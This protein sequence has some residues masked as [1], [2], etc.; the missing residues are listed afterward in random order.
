M[1]TSRS[2]SASGAYIA[3][4]LLLVHD[5]ALPAVA[6]F[7][8]GAAL[9]WYLLGIRSS[10]TSRVLIRI[11]TN[12][13]QHSYPLAFCMGGGMTDLDD[14]EELPKPALLQRCQ[15]MVRPTLVFASPIV[16]MICA[17]LAGYFSYSVFNTKP[18]A[19]MS[20]LAMSI[21]KSGDASPEMREWATDALGIQTDI[22]L[23]R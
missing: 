8:R 5:Q 12:E 1:A 6:A 14:D 19:D 21:L 13:D 4:S 18:P 2:R 10:Q 16:A 9:D 11:L 23:A 22:S 7:C 20:R 17:V 3:I 15:A